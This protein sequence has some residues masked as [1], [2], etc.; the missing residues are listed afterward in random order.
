MREYELI[1]KIAKGFIRDKNQYNTLM[2]CDAEILQIGSEMLAIT[3]DDFSPEEDF[4]TDDDPTKLG[5]NLIVATLSD[6]YAAG[7]KPKFLLQS[8]AFNKNI[9]D[10]FIEKFNFGIKSALDSANCS[11]CGGDFSTI[12]KW[13][14]T[15]CALGSIINKKF[16]QRILPYDPQILWITGKLGDANLAVATKSSTPLFELRNQEA[17]LIRNYASA[18]CDTSGGFMDAIYCM[19]QLKPDLTIEININ[20]IP[21]AN[22]LIEFAQTTKIPK[23][24]ALVGG[25]G[26]Y[27]LLFATPKN[28]SHEIKNL[29]NSNNI[30]QIGE[31]Y[32]SETS[33]ILICKDNIKK[34]IDYLPP[35]PRAADSLEEYFNQVI[36][37]TKDF[38]VYE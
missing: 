12:T 36:K 25:A 22:G 4:F 8:L 10:E 38:L 24:A 1:K 32:L 7:A 6:L 30:T 18:C 16:I 21:F 19:H 11:L 34:K 23:E 26:E 28:I 3:I 17:D 5:H 31:T 37:F 27:E 15:G 14:Y 9:S 2:S 35:C 20:N 33:G 13:H 29:F